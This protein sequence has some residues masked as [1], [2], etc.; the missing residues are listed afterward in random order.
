M[1]ILSVV[2][3]QPTTSLTQ[4]DMPPTGT[5]AHLLQGGW[6]EQSG[7]IIYLVGALVY[8]IV[9]G[10]VLT[11]LLAFTEQSRAKVGEAG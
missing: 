4:A 5:K 10:L 8:A 1:I 7:V 11:A 9:T 3:P 6:S 2:F